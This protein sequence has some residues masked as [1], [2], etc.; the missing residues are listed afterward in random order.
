VKPMTAA[1]LRALTTNLGS[2]SPV[3]FV[4]EDGTVLD[5]VEQQVVPDVVPDANG[6]AK[7]NGPP[8]LV[9]CLRPRPK[10]E[11]VN[12][13]HGNSPTEKPIRLPKGSGF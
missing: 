6:K 1:Q 8:E 10:P 13:T 4:L 5:L 7:F 12:G 3:K 11:Q 9:L 2:R